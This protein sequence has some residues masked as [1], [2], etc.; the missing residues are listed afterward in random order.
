MRIKKETLQVPLKSSD[1]I[2]YQHNSNILFINFLKVILFCF[3]LLILANEK[4]HGLES[5]SW[6]QAYLPSMAFTM[7]DSAQIKRSCYGT[8]TGPCRQED[9]EWFACMMTECYQPNADGVTFRLSEDLI[10]CTVRC[11]NIWGKDRQE[12]WVGV[13]YDNF[14]KDLKDFKVILNISS[15]NVRIQETLDAWVTIE[16]FSRG[17]KYERT[18]FHEGLNWSSGEGLKYQTGPLGS[19]QSI[20]GKSHGRSIPKRYIAVK[21][22][23]WN[24]N[25]KIP[26]TI[27]PGLIWGVENISSGFQQDFSG[28]KTLAWQRVISDQIRGKNITTQIKVHPSKVKSIS[29]IPPSA[30]VYMDSKFYFKDVIVKFE[31]R[32]I[33][34]LHLKDLKGLISWSA[35][36]GN[37]S[38]NIYTPP[39]LKPERIEITSQSH[40]DFKAKPCDTV[41]LDAKPMYKKESDTVTVIY[42][43]GPKQTAGITVL[44]SIEFKSDIIWP[45]GGPIVSISDAKD[46]EITARHS[47]S[48]IS[49]SKTIKVSPPKIKRIKVIPSSKRLEIGQ[50]VKFTAKA[51][52]EES[53][54][55]PKPI[56]VTWKPEGVVG[57]SYT[58]KAKK[59]E[60]KKTIFAYYRDP[61]TGAEFK[62]RAE[63]Q[64]IWPELVIIPEKADIL[65]GQTAHFKAY[66]NTTNLYS[67]MLAEDIE[68]VPG[69]SIIGERCGKI[70]VKAN[71]RKSGK[72]A[73]AIAKVDV[74]CNAVR[75]KLAEL[76]NPKTDPD[77]IQE[78]IKWLKARLEFFKTTNCD[79]GVPIDWEKRFKSLS[80]IGGIRKII[81]REYEVRKDGKRGHN[82]TATLTRK[83]T[84]NLFDASW[85]GT[86][87][88]GTHKEKGLSITK[89]IPLKAIE[90][91]RPGLGTYT[92]NYKDGGWKGKGGWY[93]NK[94]WYCTAVIHT[95]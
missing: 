60:G 91:S 83:G 10:P 90:I 11:N 62:G 54:L 75:K 58:F 19:Q 56:R 95:Q 93:H 71:H 21:E 45:N 17:R 43:N 74:N 42:R 26:S 39:I 3:F 84:K 24:L 55:K 94:K 23:S 40:P 4:A 13:A 77:H 38:D 28:Q 22:G 78:S 47:S 66:W 70:T 36:R 61:E 89:F 86:N 49:S 34:D 18:I 14:K 85:T 25:V 52:F 20:T 31:R 65:L 64:I 79:C 41:F 6:G 44:P 8:Y 72:S 33:N 29:I 68:W 32:Y 81:I 46:Y 35:I 37:V 50:S 69:R 1:V 16:Y 7:P 30:K 80:Y 12:C 67:R 88:N 9:C 15:A 76:R 63:V 5:Y 27:K 57:S 82:W 73:N 92:L 48:S 59:P 53:C 2:K 51:H 87:I